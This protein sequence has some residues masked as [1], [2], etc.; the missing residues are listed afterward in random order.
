MYTADDIDEIVRRLSADDIDN[1]MPKVTKYFNREL[2]QATCK[3]AIE[4]SV[5]S[6]V[7]LWPR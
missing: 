4:A 7:R 1:V 6:A 3:M 2:N 5:N